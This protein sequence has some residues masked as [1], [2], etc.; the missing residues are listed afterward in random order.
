[1]S[2]PRPYE[3][4][5]LARPRGILDEATRNYG[6]H[7]NDAALAILEATASRLGGF[8][9]ESFRKR[10]ATDE[11][12]PRKTALDIADCLLRELSGVPIHT[13]LMLARSRG[14]NS[15]TPSSE[16]RVPIT[17]IFDWL[18]TLRLSLSDDS[19]TRHAS[20]ILRAEPASSS[21]RPRLPLAVLIG[22][23]SRGG[24]LIASTRP[25]SRHTHYAAPG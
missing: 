4:Q 1:M 14:R 13:A 15:I 22:T 16:R 12:V 5:L 2:A 8:S 11:V 3:E 21:L 9:Y 6:K 20:S 25:I 7:H 24:W 10:F 19:A 17:Q 18:S 23:V